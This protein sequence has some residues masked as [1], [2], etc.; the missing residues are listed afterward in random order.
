MAFL[1]DIFNSFTGQQPTPQSTIIDTNQML[2]GGLGTLQGLTPQ[3]NAISG[4]LGAGMT[5]N[6]LANEN[7]IFGPAANQLQQGAY[8]S[9]LDQLNMGENLSPALT[10]DI[11]RKLYE[12]GAA[13]G[14]GTTNAGRGN[15]IL[16]TGLAGE[17]RGQQRRNEALR[18]VGLLPSSTS[19][20][21]PNPLDVLGQGSQIGADIRNVQ[22]AQDNYKN[23]VEQIK[24]DNFSSLLNT[25]TRLLGGVAGGF[26]GAATGNP[27]GGAMAGM[28][29]GGSVF[30]RPK[31]QGAFGSGSTGLFN[32]LGSGQGAYADQLN[33][34]RAN[35]VP[36]L[37]V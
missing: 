19:Q 11:T 5:A 6:Q 26:I 3:L 29:V 21:N 23:T 28:T 36:A 32:F 14:F 31:S 2:Q 4:Q 8:S 13:S 35:S 18:A 9:I 12:S 16:Q 37:P 30:G 17:Q 15:I 7:S 1:T 27:V 20:Y 10:N 33:A 24:A 34:A 25:G 22:A